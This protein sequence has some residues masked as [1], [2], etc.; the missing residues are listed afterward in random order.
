[1]LSGGSIDRF[2]E[3]AVEF[4]NAELLGYDQIVWGQFTNYRKCHI[5]TAKVVDNSLIYVSNSLPNDNFIMMYGSQ[6]VESL[7]GE[8][9]DLTIFQSGNQT[10]IDIETERLANEKFPFHTESGV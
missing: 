8:I 9:I 7:L 3:V 4:L 6:Q 10:K 1:M 5:R 2:Y